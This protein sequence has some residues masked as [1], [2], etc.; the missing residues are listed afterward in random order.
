MGPMDHNPA[1]PVQDEL[2]LRVTHSH[3]LS[4]GQSWDPAMTVCAK[5][6]TVHISQRKGR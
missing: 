4:L 5:M 6:N 3:G 2:G 1:S